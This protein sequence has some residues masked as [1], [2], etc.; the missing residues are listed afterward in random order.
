MG[1][2]YRS[3]WHIRHVGHDGF[4]SPVVRVPFNIFGFICKG[5]GAHSI[6]TPEETAPVECDRVGVIALLGVSVRD[7]VF[8]GDVVSCLQIV[9]QAMNRCQL[10][11]WIFLAAGVVHLDTDTVVVVDTRQGLEYV[12]VNGSQIRVGCLVDGSVSIHYELSAGM[13]ATAR[14]PAL[15]H[16]HRAHRNTGLGRMHNE[17]FDLFTAPVYATTHGVIF[18]DAGSHQHARRVLVGGSISEGAHDLG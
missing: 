12:D 16:S 7:Y 5:F 14:T 10:R 1:L 15:Y 4:G 8:V 18:N 13:A 6:F 3:R 17:M 2:Q 11:L 9:D